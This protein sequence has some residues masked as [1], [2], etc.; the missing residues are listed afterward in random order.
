MM[1]CMLVWTRKRLA[2]IALVAMV[3]LP[4]CGSDRETTQ[5]SG[6]SVESATETSIE[7]SIETSIEVSPKPTPGSPESATP[8]E[9]TPPSADRRTATGAAPLLV[10]V[11]TFQAC[12]SDGLVECWGSNDHGQ[13]GQ[14]HANEVDGTVS[15][16]DFSGATVIASGDQHVCGLV[17]STGEVFCW[18]LNDGG[19]LGTG[20][21]GDWPSA[22]Q[23]SDVPPATMLAAGDFH[24]CAVA[25]SE[26]DLWCW[27]MNSSGQLGFAPNDDG[28]ST[29][30]QVEGLSGV[31]AVDGGFQHTCAVVADGTVQCFGDDIQG[32]SGGAAPGL[33]ATVEGVSDAVDVR[34]GMYQSCAR[35]R[36]GEVRCWGSNLDGQFG[37]SASTA[38]GPVAVE[39]SE[40]GKV[41]SIAVGMKHVC[42]LTAG[43]VSC[44]GAGVADDGSGVEIDF[45]KPQPMPDPMPA[46][47]IDA[48][49]DEICAIHADA[50][51]ACWNYD[52][53]ST[54]TQR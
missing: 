23:V 38:G 51:V 19:Q 33:I 35:I 54:V 6:T 10:A 34:V 16:Q 37:S 31:V 24:T 48:N 41:D 42:A 9:S 49:Y 5:P 47:A 15:V 17:G 4:G 50:S 8:A 27:G 7:S 13:L 2:G 28:R 26:R 45:T 11:G 22:R 21:L 43:K 1:G 29:P 53:G 46:V 14:G 12:K 32:Q 39:V 36:M 3:V 30:R 40:L 25:G 44:L 52:P 20:D 18:G